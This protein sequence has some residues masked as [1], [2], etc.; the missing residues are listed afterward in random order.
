MENKAK[1]TCS[2]SSTKIPDTKKMN[3]LNIVSAIFL[4]L[5]P[6]CP[7]CWAAYASFFSFIGLN[8]IKYNSN[9]KYAI[10]L[11]FL[12]GSFLL[13]KRHFQN[14]AW[15]NITL[16]GVGLSL[17]FA[18]RYLNFSQ[19]GWLVLISLLMMASNI[20]FN[21]KISGKFKFNPM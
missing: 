13:L 11:V 19:I 16:Y 10:L 20:K 12:F 8:H 3:A 4:F 18:V 15:I 7:I 1:S 6:K 17:L 2:C 21:S 9:W 5:F 14:K